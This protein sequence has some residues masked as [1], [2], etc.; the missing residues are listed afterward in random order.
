MEL[1]NYIDLQNSPYEPGIHLICSKE[2]RT[3]V[4]I[5]SV[6]FQHNRNHELCFSRSLS[7]YTRSPCNSHVHSLEAV[8]KLPSHSVTEQQ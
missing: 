2:G 8:C 1:C 4:Y 6:H 5:G 3:N 7:K